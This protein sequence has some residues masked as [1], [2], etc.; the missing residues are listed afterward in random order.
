MRFGGFAALAIVATIG[1]AGCG[2]TSISVPDGDNGNGLGNPANGNAA[3]S[4]D[5]C[6]LF[7]QSE[8]EAILGAQVKPSADNKSGDCGYELIQSDTAVS[9]LSVTVRA[10][11]T[12][13]TLQT[14]AKALS[15]TNKVDGVGDEAYSDGKLT[16]IA[17]KK[18]VEIQAVYVGFGGT[19]TFDALAA[20]KRAASDVANGI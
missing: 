16:L 13:S 12:T 8:A 4:V 14:E 1:V 11:S 10:A 9:S 18:G 7:T 3:A 2:S 15:L 17:V 19:A 6:K 5:V 20:M